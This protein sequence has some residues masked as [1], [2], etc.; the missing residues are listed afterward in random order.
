M[1]DR[2]HCS[3]VGLDCVGGSQTTG[4]GISTALAVSQGVSF[5]KAHEP[6]QMYIVGFES[7]FSN[8]A[9][10]LGVATFFVIVS[11]IKIN[12][13]NAYA[14]SLAW[15]NFFRASPTL[16]PDE[17]FGSSLTWRSHFC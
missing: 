10:V 11:Q 7:I 1:V 17:W 16:T 9:V 5:A 12:V 4:R 14:G 8:P 2:S 6:I 3:R 13:T 15:S